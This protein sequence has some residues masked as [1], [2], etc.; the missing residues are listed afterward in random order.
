MKELSFQTEVLKSVRLS[1]GFGQKIAHRFKAGVPDLLV[2]M[3]KIGLV[4]LE[5]KALGE[6]GDK[7][8]RNTGVTVIQQEIMAKYNLPQECPVAAQL[9]YL[10]HHG[11]PRAVVWPANSAKIN[12]NYEKEQGIWVVRS[13]REPHWDVAKLAS[14]VKLTA[15]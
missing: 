5:C 2:A 13:K 15:S 8:S 4:L 6:V 9:V 11:E 3:P 14:A 10:V 1:G 12:S 7:F